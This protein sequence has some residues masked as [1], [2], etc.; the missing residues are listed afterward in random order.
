MMLSQTTRYKLTCS[1]ALYASAATRFFSASSKF[2]HLDCVSS[3][4]LPPLSN[5]LGGGDGAV[6]FLK[7]LAV[8][9]D[10]PKATQNVQCECQS[11]VNIEMRN[12]LQQQQKQLYSPPLGTIGFSAI[13]R[14]NSN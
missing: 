9:L 6:A 5:C 13:R 2:A 12:G 4:F 11:G 8:G 3:W 10:P 14:S 7:K 1:N